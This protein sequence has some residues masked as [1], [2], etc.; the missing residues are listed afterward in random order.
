MMKGNQASD[1]I[2]SYR[3]IQRDRNSLPR[4]L[5]PSLWIARRTLSAA[6]GLRR[7]G[8]QLINLS[9]AT[10]RFFQIQQTT[11]YPNDTDMAQK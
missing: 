7:A 5:W 2:I 3:L 9:Q 6:A 10:E 4:A 8:E 11:D 1:K